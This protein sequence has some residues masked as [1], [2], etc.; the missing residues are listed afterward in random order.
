[1]LGSKHKIDETIQQAISL[2]KD[3]KFIEALSVYNRIEKYCKH[4]SEE[5][6]RRIRVKEFGLAA[7]PILG[8]VVHPRIG[9][10]LDQKAATYEK[11]REY[12]LA[13]FN[14]RQVIKYEPLSCKGYLRTSKILVKLGHD[15][16]A[17]KCLQRGCYTIDRSVLKFGIEVPQSLYRNMKSQLRSLSHS[18]KMEK[19][20]TSLQK[21]T[22]VS[23]EKRLD[24]MLPIEQASKLSQPRSKKR[25]ISTDPFMYL[26]L[27]LIEQIFK[28]L[29]LAQILRC[30]LVSSTWYNSLIRIPRLLVSN[31]Y[32][33]SNLNFSDFNNAFNLIRKV[34]NQ[35]GSKLVDIIRLRSTANSNHL[36]RIIEVLLQDQNVKYRG[37]DILNKHFS[38]ELMV[39][40]LYKS[41]WKFSNF[42]N[43][44]YWRMGLNSSFKYEH[45]LLKLARELKQLEV[46]ILDCQSSDK[47]RSLLPNN[48][49][50]HELV[51]QKATSYG[52]METLTLVNHPKFLKDTVS[53]NEEEEMHIRPPF[54]DI[55]FPNLTSL[56]VVSYD[57]TNRQSQ[58][59]D[60]LASIKHLREIY[61]ENNALISIKHFLQ[62]LILTKPRFRLQK[63]VLRERNISRPTHLNEISD[64][65]IPAINSVSYVDIYSSSLTIKG[66]M[67]FLQ[68]VNYEN[69][70]KYLNIGNSNYIYFKNDRI[71]MNFAPKISL[72][73]IISIA[74]KLEELHV[75]E[76]ELDNSSMKFFHDDIKSVWGTPQTP[77]KLLN[78]SF[79]RNVEGIGLMNLFAFKYQNRVESNDH[80]KLDSLILDGLELN[81][82]TLK[83]L[84]KK[85]YVNK[86]QN[87][88]M[89]TK[90][91]QYGVNT[92]VPDI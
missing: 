55:K 88:P 81:V 5:E 9:S 58:F 13:L 87:D 12:Q 50:F 92:L 26:P 2:F 34:T 86:V 21:A 78:L 39:H 56:T 67:K 61:L 31:V 16:E 57:F 19:E 75:H 15:D 62:D 1:M 49:K 84:K 60:F 46:I 73:Q 36:A 66:L 63:L 40:K 25:K 70:L 17:L 91:K 53:S 43:S 74:N 23:L 18:L 28:H 44:R 72:Y 22:P 30:L 71:G 90:W 89:K 35:T 42:S 54:L 77:L 27:E 79:C 6:L 80:F 48:S 45:L 14:G 83:L 47:N 4:F 8:P 11:L 64:F 7:E 82:D 59:Q 32:F 76:M 3:G 10:I 29:P 24:E 52:S 69:N 68:I 85:G 38:W 65:L 41:N 33:R 51:K 37:F 20:K